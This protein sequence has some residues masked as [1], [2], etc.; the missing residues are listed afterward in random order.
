VA[1]DHFGEAAQ[2]P[3]I[4]ADEINLDS[5]KEQREMMLRT[6]K[7][8]S[9]AWTTGQTRM[10]LGIPD[11]SMWTNLDGETLLNSRSGRMHLFP[12][13]APGTEVAFRN[14]Q[15]RGAFLVSAA[16]NA[17]EVY[18]LEVQPRRDGVCRIMNPWP[19][20][21]V[22]VREAGKGEP[23]PVKVDTSNGECLEFAAVGGKTY[24]IKA[25]ESPRK[26]AFGD[27]DKIDV[28]AA[29]QNDSS[30]ATL[31]AC[32]RRPPEESVKNPLLLGNLLCDK[33]LP[34]L[35]DTHPPFQIDGN[36]GATAAIAEMLLQSHVRASDGSFEIDLLP[37]LPSAWPEGTVKGLRTR[38]GRTVDITWRAG[39]LMEVRITAKT[40][41]PAAVSCGGRKVA[42]TLTAGQTLVL[43]SDLMPAK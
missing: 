15:A 31:P 18:F 9:T 20:R 8:L 11:K 40:S 13:V 43:N 16:R 14:F 35:F 12:A 25:Q 34:N 27:P 22:V 32:D 5:P 39:R 28:P 3:T 29:M 21:T 4:L 36:F 26:T 23:V 42:F 7:K 17:S 41:G 6:C 38:G 24:S 33:T 19:G 1:A 10:L 37:A 2:Y 30:S